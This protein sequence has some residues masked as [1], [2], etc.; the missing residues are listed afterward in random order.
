MRDVFISHAE[1]DTGIALRIAGGLRA[2]GYTCWC[3]EEDSDIGYSY[4][5]QIDQE[6]EETR[7]VLLII[8]S[9]SLASA[10]V[11]KE[12][13]RAHESGKPIL[14]VRCDVSHETVQRQREWRMALGAA[15]TIPLP[16]DGADALVP[17]LVRSLEKFGITGG[18]TTQGPAGGWPSPASPSTSGGYHAGGQ[19]ASGSASGSASGFPPYAPSPRHERGATDPGRSVPGTAVPGA[20]VPGA[21]RADPNT[22]PVQSDWS[23]V[24]PHEIAG[25]LPAGRPTGQGFLV[26]MV[27]GAVAGLGVFTGL[28]VLFEAL[29]WSTPQNTSMWLFELY[30]SAPWLRALDVLGS[31]AAI[32]LDLKL[33]R[34]LWSAFQGH[35]QGRLGVRR[36]AARLLVLI[37]GWLLVALLVASAS[38]SGMGSYRSEMLAAM[39]GTAIL[40]L[41]LTGLVYVLFRDPVAS[42]GRRE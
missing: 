22:P 37:G 3:Y 42:R 27:G 34:A 26:V 13:V 17:R 30:R 19:P 23:T 9:A 20:A 41:L 2:H 6:I 21:Y 8:S 7:A 5:S 10:Q 1:E 14:P 31:A 12:I 38:T 29:G 39:T 40:A 16:P 32:L 4:L 18:L 25:L 11:T 15:V 35:A 28:K 33:L 24:L 36:A